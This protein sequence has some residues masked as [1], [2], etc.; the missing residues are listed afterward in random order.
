VGWLRA[1]HLSARRLLDIGA[2]QGAFVAAAR[3]VGIDAH[4]LELV[5]RTTGFASADVMV[6]DVITLDLPTR[7]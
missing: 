2:G 7:S 5:A 3:R 4:G 6:G 1:Y